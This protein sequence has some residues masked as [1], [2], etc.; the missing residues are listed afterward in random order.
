[1]DLEKVHHILKKEDEAAQGKKCLGDGEERLRDLVGSLVSNVGTE[2]EFPRH[3]G[4]IER[5]ERRQDVAESP[6]EQD[7]FGKSVLKV[8]NE[9]HTDVPIVF[10][11][12]GKAEKAADSHE[13]ARVFVG[14]V[15]RG[16]EKTAVSDF[17]DDESAGGHET[18]AARAPEKG[19]QPFKAS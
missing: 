8:V 18:D 15:E 2:E 19:A 14:D 12:E 11:R 13:I 16:V 4:E 7:S 3:H 6:D 17:C 5:E 9:F 10:F 1:L